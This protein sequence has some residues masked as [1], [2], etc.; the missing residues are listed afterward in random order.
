LLQHFTPIFCHIFHKIYYPSRRYALVRI[1]FFHA[2]WFEL[3]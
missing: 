1:S 3:Q 2:A